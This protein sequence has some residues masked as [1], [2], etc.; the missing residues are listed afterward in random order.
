MWF[1]DVLRIA[2]ILPL[3]GNEFLEKEMDMKVLRLIATLGF[4][5]AG[6]LLL[7]K[8]SHAAVVFA[9]TRFTVV[10]AG[11]VGKPDV[12]LIPGLSSSRTVWDA[13]AK[14]LPPNYRLHLLQVS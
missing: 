3:N 4:V 5:V 1:A 13:E 6:I 11:T 9:P 8:P 14:L 2:A 7:V 12:I 10:D